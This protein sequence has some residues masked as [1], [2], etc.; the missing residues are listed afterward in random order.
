MKKNK[1]LINSAYLIA[2]LLFVSC[3]NIE[4]DPSQEDAVSIEDGIVDLISANAAVDGMYD[5][6][7][8]R[9]YY[10]RELMV[11]PE[12]MADNILVSPANSGRYL[13]QYQ[14]SIIPANGSVTNVWDNLY[15]NI[16]AANTVLFYANTLT[17]TTQ[18]QLDE[19][20][21]HAFAIRAMAHF[22]LVRTYA[23]PYST[24]EA[25]AA[26]GANGNGG[27]LGVPLLTEFDSSDPKPRSTVAEVYIQIIND[28]NSAIQLL[29]STPYSNSSKFNV[30]AA[31]ALLAR[32][33]LY[34]EDY[35]MAYTTALEVIND[36]NYFLTSNSDY[37]A[38]DWSGTLSSN[39]GLLQLPASANDSNGFDSL[40][41]IYIDEGDD[42]N[43]GYGDLIPTADIKDLY[44]ATDVRRNWFRNIGGVDFNF[45]FPNSFTNDIPLIRLSE[46]YLIVA[47]AVANNAGSLI[48]GQ[49]ALTQ[50]IQRADPSAPSVTSSG[51][52]LLVQTLNERRKELAFE[53]HR[54][55]DIVRNKLDVIRI[56]LATPSTISTI[57]YPDY[58]MI[59]PIPE[60]EIIAND[61]IN[62]NNNGY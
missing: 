50:I 33:Y 56:D 42:G 27:H 24:T 14:Y 41:S 9:D 3:N 52:D 59:W 22:D 47:E 5:L 26:T 53:G 43:G 61:N 7:Y 44:T 51:N 21:G 31:K 10:G 29:P 32:V 17:G 58:R 8:R 40:G 39:E 55:Y 38:N 25:S 34:K 30:T 6:L 16:N 4:L 36:G 19:L 1:Y 46:M 18:E 60:D 35:P 37:I 11:T 48:V 28:L 45:K 54:M 62:E 20:N 13:T 12:I 15:K 2:L 57:N 23:F 49:D